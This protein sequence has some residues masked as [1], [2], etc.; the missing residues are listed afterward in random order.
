MTAAVFV[1]THA[2]NELPGTIADVLAQRGIPTRTIRAYAGD[3]VPSD[4]DGALGLVVM[5][6][7]QGVY[8]ADRYPFLRNEMRLVERAIAAQKPVLGVCLGSQLLAAAL[9]GEVRPGPSKEIGWEKVTLTEAG[10]KDPLWKGIES[11][12][13]ALHWHGDVFTLPAGAVSLARSDRTEHQAFRYGPLAYGIL[14]HLEMTAPL[15]AGM[16]RAFGDE[17]R[18]AGVDPDGIL[19]GCVDHLAALVA[20]G[21][22]VFASW[23][24]LLGR[25]P[26]PSTL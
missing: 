4:L 10:L 14:F 9:G 1:L 25:E 21:K 26:E 3:A 16:L 23:A 8:E 22:D 24:A 5:G 7:P 13:T 11:S 12:F 20:R 2:P 19:R 17:A 18:A 15:V 6:G